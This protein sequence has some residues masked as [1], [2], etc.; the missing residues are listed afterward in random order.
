MLYFAI[1]SSFNPKLKPLIQ[2]FF[3]TLPNSLIVPILNSHYEFSN[4]DLRLPAFYL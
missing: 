4:Q 2:E 3:L 1:L